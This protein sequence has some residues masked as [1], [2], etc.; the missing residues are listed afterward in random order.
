MAGLEGG[1]PARCGYMPWT[2]LR[3]AVPLAQGSSSRATG[4]LLGVDK[5]TVHHWLPVLGRHG[6]G[7]MHYESIKKSGHVGSGGT[8]RQA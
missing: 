4:R 5:D 7:V 6:Q 2:S 3:G 8:E 1:I